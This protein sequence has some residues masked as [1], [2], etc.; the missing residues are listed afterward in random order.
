MTDQFATPDGFRAELR[1][2]LLA[3]A[4][5]LPDR[6][7][8]S[9]EAGRSPR[10]RASARA[11]RGLAP[12]LVLAAFAVTA[13]LVLRSG[14]TLRPQPAT[15]ATVL[16][17]S[18]I[19]LDHQG[20]SRALGPGNYFYSRTAMLWRY[21][22]FSAHPYV[23]RSI[24]QEWLARSGQGRSRYQVVG[25]SGV[26]VSQRLPLTRSQDTRMRRPQARPFILSAAPEILLSYAQ[27]RRLPTDPTRLSAALDRLAAS[28][29]VDRRFPQRDVRTA[30]RFEMLRELAELPTSASLR[31]AVYRVLATTPGIRLL[32]RARDSVGRYGMAV[33][34]DV[35][36][37]QLELILNPATGELLQTSRTL[38]RRSKFYFDGKQPPGLINRA[39]YLATGIV[40]S[41]HAQL[42][43]LQKP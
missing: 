35:D 36:D 28:H 32:G 40:G 17:S 6:D 22:G 13:V 19:A 42:R 8:I 4:A 23:V 18:A 34:V 15:A 20:G 10:P 3:H 33:A 39:T 12:G 26:G 25:P 2:A 27:L 1:E 11:V 9:P 41:T 37:A 29:H 7:S 5:T 30:I 14:G 31:A 16:N 43:L 21:A 24:Q 38:L